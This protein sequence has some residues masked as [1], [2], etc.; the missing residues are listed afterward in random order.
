MGWFEE[1]HKK[2][3][4]KKERERIAQ[5]EEKEEMEGRIAS[6]RKSNTAKLQI[7]LDRF[8]NFKRQEL[9]N[10]KGYACDVDFKG[11]RDAKSGEDSISE[12]I[13]FF[14]TTPLRR[15]SEKKLTKKTSPYISIKAEGTVEKFTLEKNFL[16]PRLSE[17]V[18]AIHIPAP[19]FD[20]SIIDETYVDKLIQEFVT[21]VLRK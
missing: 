16:E 17:P 20:V 10:Q 4:E 1:E 15:G 12:T 11:G 3:E 14:R 5:K 9:K 8:R 19:L 6:I 2:R 21:E 18:R 13:L 7:V